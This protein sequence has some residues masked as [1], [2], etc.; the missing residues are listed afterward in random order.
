MGVPA[1]P[2]S[3]PICPKCAMRM[4]ATLQHPRNFECLRCGHVM[5]GPN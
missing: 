1:K 5:T 4:V 3:R 2:E